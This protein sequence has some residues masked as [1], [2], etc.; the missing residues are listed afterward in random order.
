[1]VRIVV[2]VAVLSLTH[3]SVVLARITNLKTFLDQCPQSDPAYETIR[4]DFIIRKDG[5]VVGAVPCT[6]PVSQ[7][8]AAQYTDELV[9]LQGLRAMYYMDRGQNGHL[10]WTPGSLYDWMLSK[11]RG[12]NIAGGGSFCC[13]SFDDGRYM[14]IREFDDSNREFDKNWRGIAGNIGLYAHEARHADGFPHSSCCGIDGGCDDTFDA[15]NLSP[16]GIQWWL[17]DLWL[18]GVIDVGFGCL[19][20]PEREATRQW[21]LSSV[22]SQFR[23]RFCTNK[24]DVRP[25][26]AAPACVGARRRAVRR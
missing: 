13:I 22:N 5:A 12:I 10:P 26:T 18:R 23:N 6:E 21:H 9:L 25:S 11:V 14:Q 1:M 4:R 15:G 16:Y 3:G 7:L 24:P 19:P 17:D 8:S 20:P 2:V